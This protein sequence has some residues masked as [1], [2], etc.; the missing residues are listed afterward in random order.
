[1]Q[2]VLGNVVLI[3]FIFSGCA[4][5]TDGFAPS[6]ET[7]NIPAQPAPEVILGES[8]MKYSTHTETNGWKISLSFAD[9]TQAQTLGNGWEVEIVQD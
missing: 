3:V 4:K 6:Q 2:Y 5:Q 8:F 1:M 9:P 7:P